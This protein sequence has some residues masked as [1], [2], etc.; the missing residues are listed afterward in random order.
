MIQIELYKA[1]DGELLKLRSIVTYQMKETAWHLT[2][3]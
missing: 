3:V 2:F 1:V